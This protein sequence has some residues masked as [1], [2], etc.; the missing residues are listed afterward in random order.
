MMT[1]KLACSRTVVEVWDLLSR[2]SAENL[3]AGLVS[4]IWRGIY[5]EASHESV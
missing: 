3:V 4:N 2:L 5:F 1:P